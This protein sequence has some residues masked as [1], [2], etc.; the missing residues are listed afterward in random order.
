MPTTEFGSRIA[1]IIPAWN[2]ADVLD[3]TLASLAAATPPP[4][5]V[6]VVADHCTDATADVAEKWEATVLRNDRGPAGK[7]AALAWAMTQAAA[8]LADCSVIA[9]FDADSRVAPLFF[10][11]IRKAFRRGA[12]VVQGFV[13]PVDLPQSTAVILAAYSEV[14]VQRIDGTLCTWLGGS[15]RLRGTGMAFEIRLL[16]ELLPNIR[17]QVEDVELTL[18]VADRGIRIVSVPAAVVYDPKP[19]NLTAASRQRARWFRGQF[20]AFRVHLG[21][22]RHLVRQGP[23]GWWLLQD[24]LL[25]PRSLVWLL[26]A[27]ASVLACLFAL[28]P[29]SLAALCAVFGLCAAYYL[30]G[31]MVVPRSERA[32]YA[33][34]LLSA[35]LFIAMWCLTAIT[36]WSAGGGWLRVRD[37]GE[38][39]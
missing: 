13:Y 5:R 31:L 11:E 4:D 6:L 19:F 34:A 30:G 28:S 14:L 27:F 3:Q 7:G 15:M 26:L 10:A 33:R 12:Q 8:L 9:V 24:V 1:A 35:P 16:R 21:I 29:W 38:T 17:T 36:A 39:S 23:R 32:L 25:K 2:E 22:I 18:L 20:E 37:N